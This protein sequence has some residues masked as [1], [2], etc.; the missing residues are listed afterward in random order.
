MA[1]NTSSLAHL[2]IN[3][4][5]EQLELPWATVEVVSPVL[6]VRMATGPALP[7]TSNAAGPLEVGDR[8]WCVWHKRALTVCASP[9]QAQRVASLLSNTDSRVSSLTARVG[10]VEGRATNLENWRTSFN[11]EW[12]TWPVAWRDAND[13]PLAIGNGTLEGRYQQLGRTVFFS[14][15]WERGSTTNVGTTYWTFDLPFQSRSWP[16]VTASGYFYT[17]EQPVTA[18]PISQQVLVVQ[19][20]GARLSNTNPTPATGQRLF[21]S[22]VYERA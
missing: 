2:L 16:R 15:L 8:V 6:M 21:L 7:V 9:S 12:N 10:A 5:P 13:T 22:G 1:L 11:T 14:I 3:R 20:A 19:Y 4:A 17:P 18:I